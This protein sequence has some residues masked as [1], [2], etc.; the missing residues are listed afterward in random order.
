MPR[1]LK[2]FDMVYKNWDIRVTN[3]RQFTE[4]LFR[5]TR[6]LYK[7]KLIAKRNGE[8]YEIK[9]PEIQADDK[10]DLEFQLRYILHL[11]NF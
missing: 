7:C 11:Q 1:K 8:K 2:P 4:K 6:N 3:I 10:Q 9:V 5:L